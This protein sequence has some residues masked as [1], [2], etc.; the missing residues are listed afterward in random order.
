MYGY[1][2]R[3]RD[4]ARI[5]LECAYVCVCVK[6][7]ELGLTWHEIPPERRRKSKEHSIER[8]PSPRLGM[9]CGEMEMWNPNQ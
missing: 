4:L 8:G 5:E 1:D 6:K 2:I 7:I 3:Q 9:S